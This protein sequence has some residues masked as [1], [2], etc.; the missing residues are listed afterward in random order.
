MRSAPMLNEDMSSVAD[1]RLSAVRR[2]PARMRPVDVQPEL[3]LPSAAA[4]AARSAKRAY[5]ALSATSIGL[6][7]GIAVAIGLAAGMWLDKR[8][9]TTPW[10]MLLL[11][12]LGLVAGFRNVLRAVRRSEAAARAEAREGAA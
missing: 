10:L 5:N 8:L 11:L 2:A 6:E 9:G 12:V 4:P 1:G 7:F 3:S